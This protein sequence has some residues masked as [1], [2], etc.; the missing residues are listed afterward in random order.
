V[1]NLSKVMPGATAIPV[2]AKTGEGIAQWAEWLEHQRR[3]AVPSGVAAHAA[4]HSHD[5]DHPPSHAHEHPQ[6]PA[7]GH[8][9]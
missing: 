5:H 2:S 9:H 3:H 7:H 8:S 6:S 1:H 4:G